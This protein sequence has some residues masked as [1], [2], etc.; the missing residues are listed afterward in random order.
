MLLELYIAIMAINF[1]IFGIAFF[2]KN[3]WFWAISLVLSSLLIFSS[4]NIE[5]Q[6]AVVTN[7]TAV[8][9]TVSFTYDVMT[10]SNQDWALFGIALGMFLLGLALFLND[11]FITFKEGRLGERKY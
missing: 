5:Q 9:S 4:F 7:Q 3:I 10:N 8:G 11:L 2:R 6:T 1:I